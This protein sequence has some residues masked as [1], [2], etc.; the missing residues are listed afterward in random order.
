MGKQIAKTERHLRHLCKNLNRDTDWHEDNKWHVQNE[1]QT[2]RLFG[3]ER[4]NI[5]ERQNEDRKT[6]MQRLIWRHR[7]II[8]R[9]LITCKEW[10]TDRQFGT[11]RSNRKTK[12][13]RGSLVSHT[14]TSCHK[15]NWW[16]DCWPDRNHPAQNCQWGLPLREAIEDLLPQDDM[17]YAD[18][19]GGP[20]SSN[21]THDK[22]LGWPTAQQWSEVC[23]SPTCC[24]LTLLNGKCWLFMK[25]RLIT[26]T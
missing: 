1:T 23:M 22:P 15:K 9:Q 7:R 11:E 25:M 8:W 6:F 2:E 13:S 18:G 12:W 20:W 10:D 19:Y 17:P 24:E 26:D 16:T 4:S 21:T 3:T 5:L 14:L